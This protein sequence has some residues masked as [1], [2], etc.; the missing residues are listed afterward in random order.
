MA[1][2][3]PANVSVTVTSTEQLLD[4]YYTLSNQPGGG[5][6]LIGP[7]VDG[8]GAVD[9]Y[10]HGV[11]D[12]SEPV[13]IASADPNAPAEF[14]QIKMRDVS[15]LRIENVAVDSTEADAS[16]PVGHDLIIED[17]SNIEIVGVSF[18][19]DS[20]GSLKAAG[21][22]G[23]SLGLIRGSD[24]VLF[25]DNTAI[26]YFHGVSFME[27]SSLEVIGNEF[28]EFQGDGLRFTGVQDVLIDSNRS[29][30]Q[31]GGG[32]RNNATVTGH[33]VTITVLPTREL[34]LTEPQ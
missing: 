29:E 25:Q 10:Q 31:H 6:I 2:I 24:S 27:M 12:G 23:E 16:R 4:A 7:N 14:T 3:I 1:D 13:V 21:E 20:D 9:F 22:I 28:S 19:H 17:S 8:Y 11:T 34:H 18:S 33:T 30:T 5:T 32:F 15:N 26:G